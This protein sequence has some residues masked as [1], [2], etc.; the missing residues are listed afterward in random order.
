MEVFKEYVLRKCAEEE[1]VSPAELLDNIRDPLKFKHPAKRV[2]WET[3]LNRCLHPDVFLHL[4]KN[5]TS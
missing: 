1:G 5:P 3:W 2:Y 4:L